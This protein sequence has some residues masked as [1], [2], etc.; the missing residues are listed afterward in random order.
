M[1]LWILRSK[2]SELPPGDNP[3]LPWYD[4]MHSCIVAAENEEAARKIAHIYGEDENRSMAQTAAPWLDPKYSACE[5]L[6]PGDKER[7][8]IRDVRWG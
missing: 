2:N 5:E 7:M 4:K 3:W 8:I 1:K 6:A